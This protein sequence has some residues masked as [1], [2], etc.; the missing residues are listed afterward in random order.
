MSYVYIRSERAGQFGP[1]LW[2]VGFYAPNGKWQP[3]SDHRS[4]AAAAVHTAWLNGGPKPTLHA[5][6]C[7]YCEGDL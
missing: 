2:T 6:A 4:E 3:E 1:D 7:P 5:G